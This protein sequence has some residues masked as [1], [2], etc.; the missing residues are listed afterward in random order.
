MPAMGPDTDKRFSK[1][2]IKEFKTRG[3][4]LRGLSWLIN[5]GIT[6]ALI[7][8]RQLRQLRTSFYR[9]ILVLWLIDIMI[10]LIIQLFL[11]HGLS[12]SAWFI[13]FVVLIT[14]SIMAYFMLALVRREDGTTMYKRFPIPNTLTLM[15]LFLTPLVAAAI[16]DPSSKKE[17][18]WLVFV[19]LAVA[20]ISDTLDG[21][22]ARIFKLKS[23]FGR[24]WDPAV[25]VFFHSVI[26][27]AL[28]VSNVVP[29]W[30][31]VIV[32]VRYI[33]PLLA[34]P[35]VYLF[36]SGF[37]V[38]ATWPGKLSSFLLSCFMGM[39]FIGKM[40]N[41]DALVRF[42]LHPFLLLVVGINVLTLGYFV[43]QGTRFLNTKEGD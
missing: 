43:V 37:R 41:W 25:D 1:Q 39:F 36:S 9:H 7:T 21:N 3:K 30:F 42:T 40:F 8:N 29:W 22:I 2:L 14:G 27:I 26:A 13:N 34:A 4:G 6:Y 31:M 38:K 18:T 16:M 5:T 19:L 10:A 33:L 35:F 28:F 24:A 23:D 15:R 11:P 20:A 32:L 17:N 12:I